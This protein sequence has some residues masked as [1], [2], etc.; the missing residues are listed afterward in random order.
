MCLILFFFFNSGSLCLPK[1][2]ARV[3]TCN[4]RPQM[5]SQIASYAST[6][7]TWNAQRAEAINSQSTSPV[8]FTAA[9]HPLRIPEKGQGVFEARHRLSVPF[10]HTTTP[11]SARSNSPRRQSFSLLYTPVYHPAQRPSVSSVT[12]LNWNIEKR[13]LSVVESEHYLGAMV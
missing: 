1:A 8:Q 4:Q 2:F 13:R 3:S 9:C 6:P 7:N 5:N 12:P 10:V 11:T